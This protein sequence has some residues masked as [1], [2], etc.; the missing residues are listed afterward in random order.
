MCAQPLLLR[1]MAPRVA[2]QRAAERRSNSGQAGRDPTRSR[3]MLSAEVAPL[4]SV[5]F[6][7]P[8]KNPVDGKPSW[9]AR[10][11]ARTPLRVGLVLLPAALALTAMVLT[12]C[13][14][15][16]ADDGA[17]VEASLKHYLSTPYPQQSLG[18]MSPAVGVFPLGAGPPRVRENSCKK[19]RNL[20]GSRWANLPGLPARL[21]EGLSG[22][23]CVVRFGR[24]ALPV[25]VAVKSSDEVYWAAPMSRQALPPATVYEGGPG[26]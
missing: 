1:S 15:G 14:G 25:T 9:G 17:K 19:T 10:G 24:T 12:A 13:D 5:G 16:G 23:S 3:C 7:T 18:Q 26:P 4:R 8:P 22:W 21:P 6:V 11:P 20:A 2:R